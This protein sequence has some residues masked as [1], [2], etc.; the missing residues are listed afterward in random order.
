MMGVPERCDIVVIGGG[1]GGATAAALLSQKGYEVVLFEKKRYPRYQVGESLIPHFWKY[2]DV[3]GASDSIAAE[4]FVEKAGGTVVWDGV[5]RQMAFRDFGYE[6]PALHI[7]RDR[8]DQLMLECAETQGAQVFQETAVLK[9]VLGESSPRVEYRH[10]GD[11]ASDELACRLV[12][13]ASGQSAVIAKQLRLRMI[14]D[15]FRFMSLWGYFRDSKFVSADGRALAFSELGSNAP[16]TFVCS[17]AGLGDWGWAWHIPLREST[18]VGLVLPLE[19]MAAVKHS[20]EA[21][22]SY[23]LR[24]CGET[25]YLSHLLEGATFCEGSFHIIRDYSY[26]SRKLAG[27]GFYLIGDA[28]AFIDPIFSVGVVLAMYSGFLAAWAID[29]SLRRS[30]TAANNR[31]IF[32][33]QFGGRL[34]V[35]RSLALPRYGPAGAA[36]ELARVSVNF[37]SAIEKELMHLVSTFTTRSQNLTELVGEGEVER[38]RSERYKILE[39]IIF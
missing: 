20:N 4:G 25:P 36:T 34:E 1:P 2:S 7:E 35:A 5:I 27:P 6:R 29:R 39:D 33:R 10:T 11:S 30:E 26:R 15:A 38:V 32:A 28:C 23:F 17:V 21:L 19:Q 16:T 8:F 22:E 31:A 37:E 24:Q 3:I 13:D 18:S 12:I 9:A 14:D